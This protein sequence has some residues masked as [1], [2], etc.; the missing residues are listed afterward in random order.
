MHDE[1]IDEHDDECSKMGRVKG[2]KLEP[3]RP[4]ASPLS[5]AV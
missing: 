1:Y 4:T 2:G 3:N 5:A